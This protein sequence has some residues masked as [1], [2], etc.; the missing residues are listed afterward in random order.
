MIIRNTSRIPNSELR[1]LMSFVNGFPKK[2]VE[3]RVRNSSNFWS[4]AHIYTEANKY[5][6]H[7]TK[8]RFLIFV[9]LGET[10][11]PFLQHYRGRGNRFPTYELRD[12]N[13]LFLAFYAHE[14]QHMKNWIKR[15]RY[16][17]LRPERVALRTLNRYREKINIVRS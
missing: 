10:T 7:N 11:F 8:K 3:L 12:I 6:R 2:D 15:G 17:E 5:S 14:C 1:R 4:S 16:G 9:R 13:E